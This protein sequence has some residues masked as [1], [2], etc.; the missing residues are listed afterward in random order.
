MTLKGRVQRVGVVSCI[1]DD[2]SYMA[3]N[4]RLSAIRRLYTTALC[5]ESLTYVSDQPVTINTLS[6]V[7]NIVAFA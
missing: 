7:V 5:I 2:L 4:A 1:T 3:I 6:F